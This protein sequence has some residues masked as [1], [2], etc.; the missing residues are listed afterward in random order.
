MIKPDE[1][2][3]GRPTSKEA[4][5]GFRLL[6]RLPISCYVVASG[7]APP[8]YCCG[9]FEDSV[10]I[11]YVEDYLN[12]DL[13]RARLTIASGKHQSQVFEVE[14]RHEKLKEWKRIRLSAWIELKVSP[15][16]DGTEEECSP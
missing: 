9:G 14:V 11:S 12:A 10:A 16:A 13:H 7:F 4:D 3:H 1:P 8:M 5:K 15:L 2:K 6:Q